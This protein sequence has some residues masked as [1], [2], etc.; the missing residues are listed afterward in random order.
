MKFST[1]VRQTLLVLLLVMAAAAALCCCRQE[2][3]TKSVANSISSSSTSNVLYLDDD[4]MVTLVDEFGDMDLPSGMEFP[5]GI[6]SEYLAIE[7]RAW[8][9]RIETLNGSLK[10]V[11]LYKGTVEDVLDE[12]GFWDYPATYIHACTERLS[13]NSIPSSMKVKAEA[14]K[15]LCFLALNRMGTSEASLAAVFSDVITSVADGEFALREDYAP[16][17]SVRS[18]EVLS[19][20]DRWSYYEFG[21]YEEA[22]GMVKLALRGDRFVLSHRSDL[23]VPCALLWDGSR[24]LP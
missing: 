6:K 2:Y 1:T 14:A 11:G 7:G 19:G 4:V 16:M 18:G 3:K 22:P 10:A 24:L 12:H 8:I 9:L 20:Q 5:T 13:V 21:T 23:H 17:M 15:E